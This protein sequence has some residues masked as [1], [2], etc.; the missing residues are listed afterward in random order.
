VWRMG[1]CSLTRIVL[2]I[3]VLGCLIS[4]CGSWIA[5]SK[6][7]YTIKQN[8]LTEAGLKVE[9]TMAV[10]GVLISK[11]VDYLQCTPE[12]KGAMR[13]N[14][15]SFEGCDGETDWRPIEMCDRSCNID[16]AAVPCGIEV[17]DFASQSSVLL[18][19]PNRIFS[20]RPSKVT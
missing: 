2:P 18:A 16:T 12:R 5:L 7:G 3:L 9:G 11:P 6:D 19:S 1:V 20:S 8:L 17:N 10:N 15:K 13:W 14:D 4:P